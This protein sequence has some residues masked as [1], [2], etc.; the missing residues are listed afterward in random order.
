MRDTAGINFFSCLVRT[1]LFISASR[2]D[3]IEDLN[4]A[5]C[6]F[7]SPTPLKGSIIVSLVP[8]ENPLEERGALK[9]CARH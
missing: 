4:L 2:A 3:A 8:S 9:H 5:E 1:T 7:R 6:Y